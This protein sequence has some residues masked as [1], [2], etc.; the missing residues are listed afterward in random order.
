[1]T[2][3]IFH[4]LDNVQ[5]WAI[6]L[7][8]LINTNISRGQELIPQIKDIQLGDQTVQLKIFMQPGKEITYVH[9]HENETASLEAGLLMLK[10]YGGKLITLSHSTDGTKNRNVTFTY[11]K[12]TYRFDPNRIYTSD[13][14]VL[15]SSIQKIKG[16]GK[17]DDQI[18]SMVKNL[19]DRIW[20]ACKD[21]NFILA[22]HNNKNTPAS[23]KIRWLFW[24]HIEP[25]SFSIKSYIKS[26]YQSSDSN[27]S[28]A[29]IYINPAIN[30]SEFFIVTQKSDFD[31]L[32]KKKYSVVLQNDQPLDDG[33]MSVFASGS[34][35]RYVNSEAKMGNVEDQLK[36]LELL[37]ND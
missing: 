35:K 4:P 23:F 12:T 30:N 19:A 5:G 32:V 14:K 16:K 13:N 26:H 37:L 34:G 11:Q 27:K 36:M 22:I 33:S 15:F 7:F 18:L 21:D 6:I 2:K 24:K 8:F 1:M 31:M 28:C 29:E 20:E 3:K 9:V 17:V 25:E 10:K